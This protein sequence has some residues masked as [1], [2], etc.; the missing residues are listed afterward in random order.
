LLTQPHALAVGKLTGKKSC[1]GGTVDKA[2]WPPITKRING[3]TTRRETGEVTS[4][5]GGRANKLPIGR[6]R[7]R[8]RQGPAGGS[9]GEQAG[10]KTAVIVNEKSLY[11]GQEG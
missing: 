2:S 1:L 5:R 7:L 6:S 8:R 3:R 9:I 4:Y 11:I 10:K